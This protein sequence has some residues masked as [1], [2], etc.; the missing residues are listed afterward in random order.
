MQLDRPHMFQAVLSRARAKRVD[1]RLVAKLL[2]IPASARNRG[3][4]AGWTNV[5]CGLPS[6]PMPG[7]RTCSVRQMDQRH[8][9]ATFHAL[10][11]WTV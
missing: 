5:V 1:H 7:V 8:P 10:G 4:F 3:V 2:A 9:K 6:S 11:R